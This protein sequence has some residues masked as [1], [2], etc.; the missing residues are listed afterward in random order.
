MNLLYGKL[1]EITSENGILFGKIAVGG[2]RKKIPL[3]LLTDVAC[4][5]KI[6]VCD[7]VAISKVAQPP[8]EET[9]HVPGDSRKTA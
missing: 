6:L 2:A 9:K 1:I 8:N 3:D 5:D 4:G 7:G